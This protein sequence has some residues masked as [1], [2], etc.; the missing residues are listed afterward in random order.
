MTK[1]F[2]RDLNSLGAH[3]MQ[4][5]LSSSLHGLSLKR[6]SSPGGIGSHSVLLYFQIF[7]TICSS[8]FL[9][10]NVVKTRRRFIEL[11]RTAC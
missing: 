5:R 3:R 4:A 2:F 8:I 7:P 6:N 10:K 1:Q 9:S 11:I